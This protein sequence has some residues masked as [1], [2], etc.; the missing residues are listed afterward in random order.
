MTLSVLVSKVLVMGSKLSH[1][2]VSPANRAVVRPQAFEK[3]VVFEHSA[4]LPCQVWRT[5]CLEEEAVLFVGNQLAHATE[6]RCDDRHVGRL[7]FLNDERRI[8][9]HRRDDD[10]VEVRQDAVDGAVLVHGPETLCRPS[11]RAACW[12]LR[13]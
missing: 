2:I 3:R 8:L 4:E 5:A 1:L 7:S 6:P 11:V 12:S 9:P 13:T 10:E